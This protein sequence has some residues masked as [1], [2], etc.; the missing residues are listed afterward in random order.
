MQSSEVITYDKKKYDI[1][2]KTPQNYP[3]YMKYL[4]FV[5]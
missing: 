5:L 4:K 3:K 1:I 2:Y